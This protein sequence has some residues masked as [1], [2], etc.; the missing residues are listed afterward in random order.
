MKK[1]FIL[2]NLSGFLEPWSQYNGG[3]TLYA[4]FIKKDIKFSINLE[5]HKVRKGQY[6]WLVRTSNLRYL[7]LDEYSDKMCSENPLK[8][9][10]N[11]YSVDCGADD[12]EYLYLFFITNLKQ[13]DDIITPFNE[14]ALFLLTDYYNAVVNINSNKFGA[15]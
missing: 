7:S 9:F 5:V 11:K 13:G 3:N 14:I 12:G 8:D 1:D 6:S 10:I 4:R 15:V 2:E